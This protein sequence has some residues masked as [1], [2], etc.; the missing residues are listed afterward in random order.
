MPEMQLYD[1]KRIDLFN[2]ICFNMVSFMVRKVMIDYDQGFD[3]K[4]LIF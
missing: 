4:V 3:P 2:D 1:D